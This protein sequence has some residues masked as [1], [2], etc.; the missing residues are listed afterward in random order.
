MSS[1]SEPLLLYTTWPTAEA[2]AEAGRQL[3]EERLAACVNILPGALSIY[4]WEDNVE[5]D[6]EA[7]MIVK[8]VREK[9]AS[10]RARI[11]ALHAF[12][13][14]AIIAL[15]PVEAESSPDYWR[16]LC[17]MGVEGG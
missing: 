12:D 3:V 15:E 13:T 11:I 8:T 16:W 17:S 6:T 14:P 4:R 5:A 9:A 1:M 10:L 2:A 7:V